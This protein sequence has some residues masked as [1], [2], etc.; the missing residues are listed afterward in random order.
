MIHMF[1]SAHYDDAI[2][3][4]GGTINKLIDNGERATVITVFG[5]EAT[6]PYSAHAIRLHE[7]WGI[8]DSPVKTR[9]QENRRA[10][11]LLAC[12]LRD[13]PF[14]EALY[15]KNERGA[16]L[17]V[18]SRAIFSSPSKE[19]D[20]LLENIISTIL[21]TI[22]G[23]KLFFPAAIGNHV[24]HQ[25]LRK[26]GERLKRQGEPVI[27]YH[28]FFYRDRDYENSLKSNFYVY[29]ELFSKTQFDKKIRA[30]EAYKSQIPGLFGSTQ[31]MIDWFFAHNK[32]A[33]G[34]YY[35]KYYQ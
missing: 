18:D 9:A 14:E 31:A 22:S 28:D 3:S 5:K 20:I 2:G 30:F 25:I 17:Y 13:L 12:E 23:D 26:V 7:N 1:F 27:F 33:N 4:C 15:R 10:C 34:D 29:E 6:R 16:N 24:D 32:T 8:K 21:E 11:D 19:D 35:E